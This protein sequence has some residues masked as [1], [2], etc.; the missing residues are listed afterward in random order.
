MESINGIQPLTGKTLFPKTDI[1]NEASFKD[2]FGSALHQVNSLQKDAER[3]AGEVVLGDA[4][5]FHEVVIA[6]EKAALAL[7]LLVQFQN[8]AVDAYHEIMRIQL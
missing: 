3:K 7:Q 2:L 5:S 6:T 4:N 8:K 1:S